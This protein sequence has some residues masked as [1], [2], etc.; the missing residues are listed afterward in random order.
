MTRKTKLAIAFL[1]TLSLL[2][3][4]PI[5]VFKANGRAELNAALA[6]AKRAGFPLTIEDAYGKGVRSQKDSSNFFKNIPDEQTQ[7]VV[8]Q[9]EKVL[10][11]TPGPGVGSE[12]LSSVSSYFEHLEQAA[13]LPDFT[14]QRDWSL[15]PDLTFPEYSNIK[16]GVRA[17]CARALFRARNNNTKGAI[18]DTER[19]VVLANL[20]GQENILIAK[21]VAI[22]CDA[23]IEVSASKLA[24]ECQKDTGFLEALLQCV[25]KIKLPTTKECVKTELF[26]GITITNMVRDSK[27]D[28]WQLTFFDSS[29]SSYSPSVLEK[30]KMVR[31]MW[32]LDYQ[33]ADYIRRMVHMHAVWGDEQKMKQLEADIPADSLSGLILPVMSQLVT[34]EK[35]AK[36]YNLAS[37]IAISATALRAKNGAW[38]TL[39]VAAKSINVPIGDPF[40]SGHL[41][42]LPSVNGLAVFS[43]GPNGVDNQAEKTKSHNIDD[44]TIQIK[45]TGIK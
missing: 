6:E 42:Y 1:L 27:L 38:P 20:P 43:V 40:S 34:A 29:H 10:A 17:L 13:T 19:A 36:A 30:I 15:G 14:P 12:I 22:A 21:L 24:S 9:L 3:A 28:T 45:P 41:G 32:S 11:A 44:I 8:S 35:R 39:E 37:R 5:L 23:I 25:S 16:Y 7:K 2:F 26:S 31:M 18:Q 33:E 4:I